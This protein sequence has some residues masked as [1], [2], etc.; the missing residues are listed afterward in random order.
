MTERWLGEVRVEGDELNVTEQVTAT[1]K[2]SGRRAVQAAVSRILN[3]RFSKGTKRIT[4]TVTRQD[5]ASDLLTGNDF[6]IGRPE[7]DETA[8]SS[9]DLS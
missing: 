6:L 2:S 7:T 4:I 5:D 3:G 1:G 8:N 9:D